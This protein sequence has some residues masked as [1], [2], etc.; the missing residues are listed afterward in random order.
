M[1]LE[2]WLVLNVLCLVSIVGDKIIA[3]ANPVNLVS[4]SLFRKW[5]WL[6]INCPPLS[7]PF[8]GVEGHLQQH[9]T[10]YL[11]GEVSYLF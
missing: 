2:I 4:P 5:F 1:C 8:K 9:E 6:M 7:P 10:V 3:D 11:F